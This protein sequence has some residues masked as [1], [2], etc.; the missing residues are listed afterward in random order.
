MEGESDVD[1]SDD[2]DG[3]C[4]TADDEEEGPSIGGRGGGG[5]SDED[6]EKYVEFMNFY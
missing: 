3:R 1:L 6:E 5:N 2:E 4:G